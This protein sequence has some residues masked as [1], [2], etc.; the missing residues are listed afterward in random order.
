MGVDQAKVKKKVLWPG[1]LT[2]WILIFCFATIYMCRLSRFSQLFSQLFR[3]RSAFRRSAQ[4]GSAMSNLATRAPALRHFTQLTVGKLFRYAC[5]CEVSSVIFL[6]AK[7][8]KFN[9]RQ[10]TNFL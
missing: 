7:K 10:W 2:I 3:S 8:K 4:R 9:P 6:K 1:F 5:A